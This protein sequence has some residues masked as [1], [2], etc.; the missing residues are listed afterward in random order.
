MKNIASTDLNQ[1]QEFVLSFDSIISKLEAIFDD[2]YRLK[3]S[4]SPRIGIF[5]IANDKEPAKN[6]TFAKS[7]FPVR[8]Y[9]EEGD[10]S[11]GIGFK[12]NTNLNDNNLNAILSPQSHR[13]I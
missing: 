4:N 9:H 8:V 5:T 10:Q 13:K 6:R 1:T 7:R 2:Y 11:N 12:Q 3:N